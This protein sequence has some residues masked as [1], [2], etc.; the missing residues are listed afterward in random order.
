MVYLYGVTHGAYW[1]D[2]FGGTRGEIE[3]LPTKGL[4]SDLEKFPK[5]TKIGLESLSKKD[6]DE[7]KWHLHDLPFNPPKPR[8]KDQEC[9]SKPYYTNN[10]MAYWNFL[11]EE[12]SNLG[13][14]ILFLE[15]KNIWFE[16]NQVM[17]KIAE[18]KARM[19]NRL[20]LEKG[21]SYE[22][23]D[24]KRIGL[25]IE[26][27][28]ENT[29]ARKIHEIERGNHLLREIKS[30][31]ASI[32]VVGKAHAD[33]WMAN[34]SAMQSNFGVF[35]E[36]Y[37]TEVPRT[38]DS[39]RGLTVFNKDA[40][41]DFRNAFIRESLEREIKLLD[42]GRF[43]DREPRYIGTWDVH[44]PIRGYFEMFVNGNKQVFGKV[45]GEIIDSLG[46][47]DFEGEIS[48]K[49]IRFIK[50]YRQNKS[51]QDAILNEIVYKGIIRNGNVIGYFSIEGFK[52]PFYATSKKPKDF[53]DLGMSW[54]SSEKRYKKEIKSLIE[55][56][57]D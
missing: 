47:A 8:F 21:E 54:V 29:L 46:D 9:A 19:M 30:S 14:D 17:I 41:P 26:E 23:Y 13:F 31:G 25:I 45:N 44:D 15:D 36:S 32:A 2:F 56:S 27:H 38:E 33:Y 35:F 34:S 24:R 7:V 5:G 42:S 18:N 12:C 39:W 11:E 49:E 53:I 3:I 51:S 22:H 52:K 6:L 40:K 43:F 20:V 50:R 48:N 57:S 4:I 16:Y 1:K 37:S 28:K 55:R 10:V